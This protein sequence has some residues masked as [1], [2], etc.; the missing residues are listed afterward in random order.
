MSSH[1]QQGLPLLSMPQKLMCKVFWR[2]M[3]SLLNRRG[4][5]AQSTA[6][7][8]NTMVE[9]DEAELWHATS[10]IDASRQPMRVHTY[11]SAVQPPRLPHS[12][13]NEGRASQI[14][15]TFFHR[16][17]DQRILNPRNESGFVPAGY[18][19][20]WGLGKSL[21]RLANNNTPPHTFL[22]TN[23][24]VMH[25]GSMK[26]SDSRPERDACMYLQVSVI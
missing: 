24:T 18:L 1:I 10:R 22:Y 26:S 8:R 5:Q 3:E 17:R 7:N 19:G 11:R 13:F 14:A 2:D 25:R 16:V 21:G 4:Q 12:C 6:T 23:S 9:T 20:F 15:L